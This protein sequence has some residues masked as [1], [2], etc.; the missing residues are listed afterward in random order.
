MKNKKN[1]GKMNFEI[2]I[3]KLIFSVMGYK[4]NNNIIK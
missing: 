2:L 1:E 4:V 3:P